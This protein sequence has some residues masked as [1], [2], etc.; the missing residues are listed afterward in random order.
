MSEMGTFENSGILIARVKL[1]NH[2][3][4]FKYLGLQQF[5][6]AFKNNGLSH[7]ET[8]TFKPKLYYQMVSILRLGTPSEIILNN[9]KQKIY[10]FNKNK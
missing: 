1:F 4:A 6:G 9:I 8:C 2:Q 5:Q 3:G 10:W 7:K